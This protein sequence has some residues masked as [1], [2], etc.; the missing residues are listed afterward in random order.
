M[1]VR[2]ALLALLTPCAWAVAPEDAAR[3]LAEAGAGQVV[4]AQGADAGIGP[5]RPGA[6]AG[7][8]VV[9]MH[10]MGDF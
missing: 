4:H 3:K 1:A 9:M 5:A 2:V 10:G 6:A 8:P 7:T